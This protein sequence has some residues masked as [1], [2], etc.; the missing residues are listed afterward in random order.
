MTEFE[1]RGKTRSIRLISMNLPEG[2]EKIGREFF[3]QMTTIEDIVKAKN[4][5]N[6]PQRPTYLLSEKFV[7]LFSIS[8]ID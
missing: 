2:P 8:V 6:S 7:K 4:V 5:L 1:D 3:T